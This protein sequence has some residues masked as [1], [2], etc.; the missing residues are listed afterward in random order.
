[1]IVEG[2]KVTYAVIPDMVVVLVHVRPG[3]QLAVAQQAHGL[4]VID[5]PL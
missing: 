2:H 1:M 3:Q 4:D 5:V